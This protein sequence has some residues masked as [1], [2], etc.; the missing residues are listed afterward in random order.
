MLLIP[1]WP[2]MDGLFFNLPSVAMRLRLPCI[3]SGD[4]P[5]EETLRTTVMARLPSRLNDSMLSAWVAVS[6]ATR[7]Q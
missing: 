6:L 3:P 5:P 7:R 4:E 2:F 1:L